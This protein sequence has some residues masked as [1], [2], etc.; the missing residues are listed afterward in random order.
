MKYAGQV[1]FSLIGGQYYFFTNEDV[2]AIITH[3]VDYVGDVEVQDISRVHL[4]ELISFD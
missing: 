4:N 1:K 2:Y 3:L